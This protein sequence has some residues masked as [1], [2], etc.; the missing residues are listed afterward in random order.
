MIPPAI[1]SQLIEIVGSARYHDSNEAR[2]SYSYDATPNFQALPDAVIMPKSKEEIQAV[3]KICNE[4]GIP[5]V[6]RGSGTNLSAG[7]CPTQGGI[8]LVFNHM[9]RILEI[10]EENLTVTVQ[11]GVITKQLIE[12]VEAGGCFIP[13]T[14]AR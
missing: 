1:R 14:P 8:V 13:R 4:H 7:T 2:L 12:A 9:N 3:L 11:P 6:P 10:D 5:I